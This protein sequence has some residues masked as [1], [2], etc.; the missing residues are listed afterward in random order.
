MS[1]ILIVED[2]DDLRQELVEMLEE[3]GHRILAA[4]N[5]AKGLKLLNENAVQLVISDLNLPQMDGLSL[6][7]AC[8]AI[9]PDV[10]F[11]MMTAFGSVKNAVEAMREG[12]ADYLIKP[13]SMTELIT[14]AGRLIEAADLRSENKILKRELKRKIGSYEMVGA[15]P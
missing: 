6:L 3:K 2:E 5:G 11:V 10:P 14:K 7:R 4:E 12:A 8:R 15:S 13:L 9:S 1:T